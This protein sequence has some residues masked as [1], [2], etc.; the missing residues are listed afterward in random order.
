MKRK[1]VSIPLFIIAIILA[2]YSAQYFGTTYDNF[3]YT[4]SSWIGSEDSWN[5]IIGFPLSLIFFLV[6]LSYGWIFKT[7]K[8]VLW[9]I[10]PLL[11]FELAA[12]V[13]HIYIP[14]LLIV[15]AFGLNSLI[16]LIISKFKH[17]NPPMVVNK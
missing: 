8:A 17:P 9:L 3:F 14:V 6:L 2:Y 10:S 12:D 5:F 4:G 16:R 1:L 11:L 7:K 15:V 13:R